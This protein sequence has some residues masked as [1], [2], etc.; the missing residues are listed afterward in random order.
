[1]AKDLEC[2]DL[3]LM[4]ACEVLLVARRMLSFEAASVKFTVVF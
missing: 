3:S 1:M 2:S 4:L